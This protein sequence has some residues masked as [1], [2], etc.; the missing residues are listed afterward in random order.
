V[1]TQTGFS[2]KFVSSLKFL[3]FEL[4]G[5]GNDVS[6]LRGQSQF[7]QSLLTVII[8]SSLWYN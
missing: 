5:N 6:N 1:Y 8:S 3:N 7:M 4:S 2:V